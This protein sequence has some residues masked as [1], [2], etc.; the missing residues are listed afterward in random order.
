MP[1]KT[2]LT[3]FILLSF[4]AAG[5]SS[6][7]TFE[8]ESRPLDHGIIIDGKADDWTGNIYTVE[9]ERLSL[10]LY[11]DR[12]DLYVCLIAN[13]PS[14]MSRIMDQGLTIWFDPSGGRKKALGIK[15][16][17][18]RAMA[19]AWDKESGRKPGDGAERP[20]TAPADRRNG[21]GS[22]APPEDM[23][24]EMEV[25]TADGRENRKLLIDE[26]PGLELRVLAS[27][28]SVVY[29]LKIPLRQSAE[30]AIAVGIDPGK[31]LGLGFETGKL[32]TGTRQPARP[33]SGPEGGGTPPMGGTGGMG[34]AGGMG[35]GVDFM[36]AARIRIWAVAKLSAG[37]AMRP[38]EVSSVSKPPED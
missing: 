19:P 28:T 5:C 31:A 30:H 2:R 37:G 34:P 1:M 20:A 38:A 16:P 17:A 11:N 10:G 36:A 6:I 15:Y 14:S 32:N 33:G 23:P 24:R 18:G 12:D 4:L 25:V 21:D 3:L 29:E 8:T 35:Q 26:V 13:D 7:V 27:Y 9:G 22:V